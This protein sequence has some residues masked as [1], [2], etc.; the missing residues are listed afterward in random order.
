MEFYTYQ[1]PN[2]LRCIH[3]Q[4]KNTV[5]HCAMVINAGSRD[6]H[7]EEYGMAHLTEHAFFKGT[8]KRRAWQVNCRLEN[9]GGE[10]NAFTTKEDTTIHATTLR[11]DFAKSVELIDDIVFHSTFPDRELEREKEEIGRAHV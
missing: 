1:L 8:Q 11:G 7:K 9:L 2:G 10:L 4:V 3:R 6:E 5:A